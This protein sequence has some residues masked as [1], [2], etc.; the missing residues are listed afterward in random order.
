MKKLAIFLCAVV[1][2]FSAAGNVWATP[3]EGRITSLPGGGM[4]GNDGWSDGDF[5]VPLRDP[6]LIAD[7]VLSWKVDRSTVTGYWTYE[8]TFTVDE[9]NPSH[10]IIE[11]SPNFYVSNIIEYGTTE[12]Y[13]L[14]TYGVSYSNPGIP[15][16]GFLKGIKW[17]NPDETEE[18]EYFQFSWTIV[19]DKDP[20]WGDFYAKDGKDGDDWAY[21]Y[22]AGFGGV[23][24]DTTIRDGNAGG[25]VL[26]PDTQTTPV[27]EPATLLLLGSGLIGLAGIGRKKLLRSKK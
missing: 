20:M 25:W 7:A 11:V 8:Y 24:L 27:P 23:P 12:G 16:S 15:E 13:D 21:A 22:N 18:A 6:P 1:L 2:V 19:T 26:V 17:N 5:N 9:K 14:D 3:F 4:T 10:V